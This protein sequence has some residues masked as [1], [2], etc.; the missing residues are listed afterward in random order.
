MIN[1]EFWKLLPV[2]WSFDR[3]LTNLYKIF[4]SRISQ[5]SS[6]MSDIG[7]HKGTKILVVFFKWKTEFWELLLMSTLANWFFDRISTN[8]YKIFIS[9]I[10]QLIQK[11]SEIII[12]CIFWLVKSFFL[13]KSCE[14]WELLLLCNLANPFS[15]RFSSRLY[16][17]K[18]RQKISKGI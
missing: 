16:K 5:L 10:F 3:F 1:C 18:H 6:K 13:I 17:R 11:M 12:Q 4:L 15:H 2:N 14:F 8:I 9:R 7:I